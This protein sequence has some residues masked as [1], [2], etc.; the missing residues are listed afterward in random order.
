MTRL[1]PVH[2]RLQTQLQ[3]LRFC[4]PDG[5]PT[6][7]AA[8]SLIDD[9]GQATAMVLTLARPADWGTLSAVWRGVQA[10]LGLPAPAIAVNGVDGLQLWF[11]LQQALPKAQAHGFLQALCTRYMPGIAPQRIGLWPGAGEGNAPIAPARQVGPDRWSAFV[12]PD[13]APVF[14]DTPWLDIPPNPEG[15]AELLSQLAR[16]APEDMASALGLLQ[17]APPAP[18]AAT[19]ASAGASVDASTALFAGQHASADPHRFLLDVMRNEAVPLALRI[20]AAKALLPY[21]S[22]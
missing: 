7:D 11:S 18:S 10:D 4:P 16:I 12:A 21:T 9:Q 5:H 1:P 17:P 22:A 14:E 8:A 13:L 6:D 2:P 20:E 3:R 15:Q 19:A